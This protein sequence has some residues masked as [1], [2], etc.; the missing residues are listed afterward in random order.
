MKLVKIRTHVYP[1]LC[2]TFLELKPRR[3]GFFTI[4]C[5]KQGPAV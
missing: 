5:Y 1:D 2:N 4:R 3:Y